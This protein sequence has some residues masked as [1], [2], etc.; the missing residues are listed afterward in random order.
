MFQF[1]KGEI[2]GR[3]P[4][5]LV[6]ETGGLGFIVFVPEN[7]PLYLREEGETIKV[8]TRMIL[9]ED[10]VSI[11]GF[12]NREELELFD[13]LRTVNGIGPKAALSILSAMPPLEVKRAI[14]FS[15]LDM[16]TRANGVGKK[17]ASRIVL[18][19]K[20]KLDKEGLDI[21]LEGITT[22]GDIVANSEREVALEGLMALG[23]SRSEGV[24]ALSKIRD[25]GLNSEDYIKK[26][27][28]RLL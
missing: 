19:L 7:S 12:S 13:L 18:E 8:H 2:A 28:S 3:F 17:T 5:G 16:L 14:V 1:I 23:Y 10:D 9:R 24:A 27:L 11:Y 6:I 22:T 20:D 4:G 21:S 15:D 25:E 26:A